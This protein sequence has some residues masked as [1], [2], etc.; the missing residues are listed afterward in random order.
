[1]K[2]KKEK[3]RRTK[4]R[5]KEKETGRKKENDMRNCNLHSRRTS[6]VSTL[7]L[8]LWIICL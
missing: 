2:R 3:K 7:S 6:I 8:Y 5:R 1:M 4:Q